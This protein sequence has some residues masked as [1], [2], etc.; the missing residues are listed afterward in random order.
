MVNF[1]D[2]NKM[3]YLAPGINTKKQH[4]CLNR[5]KFTGRSENRH[6]FII[7]LGLGYSV[8]FVSSLLENG[9]Q[10]QGKAK[11]NQF[12]ITIGDEGATFQP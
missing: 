11:Q 3:S 5:I 1:K 12:K 10:Q 2:S 7:I 8:K 4:Q 9:C 6:K